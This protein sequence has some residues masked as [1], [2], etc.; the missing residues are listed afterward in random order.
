MDHLG[1]GASLLELY[2]SN[3][4]IAVTG[5]PPASRSLALLVRCLLVVLVVHVVVGVSSPSQV[6]R[7]QAPGIVAHKVSGSVLSIS[8]LAISPPAHERGH[9]DRSPIS[10]TVCFRGP[11]F[12]LETFRALVLLAHPFGNVSEPGPPA[13]VRH[14]VEGAGCPLLVRS[15]W[16][17]LDRA[18]QLVG[19]PFI[20][21]ENAGVALAGSQEAREGQPLHFAAVFDVAGEQQGNELP[22][23]VRPLSTFEIFCLHVAESQG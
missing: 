14:L 20:T 4:W 10:S 22:D 16:H 19:F 23:E 18:M 1:S 2:A 17:Q 3:R 9:C 13:R 8:G 11:E 7:V 5:Y 12:Q 15:L 6:S 21:A